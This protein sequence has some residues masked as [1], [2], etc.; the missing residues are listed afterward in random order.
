MVREFPVPVVVVPVPVPVDPVP[1]I[2]AAEFA[3]VAD[4]PFPAAAAVTAMK[5]ALPPGSM[6]ILL[7]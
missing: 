5:A 2:A 4:D 1:L 3:A 6:L 7:L